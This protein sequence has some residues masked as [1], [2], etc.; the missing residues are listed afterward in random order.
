MS[1]SNL[2]ILA[3]SSNPEC[4]Q[5]IDKHLD[6]YYTIQYM[7]NGGVELSYD[8]KH[9]LMEGQ[10]FWPAYP[11]P[12]LAF[13]LAAGYESWNHRHVGF[14]GD[15]VLEWMEAGIWLAQPQAAPPGTDYEAFFEELV[16]RACI[17]DAWSRRLTINAIERLLI[18]LAQ[19]RS[20]ESTGPAAYPQWLQ[21]VLAQMASDANCDYDALAASEGMS[22]STLRRHFRREMGLSLHKYAIRRRIESARTLLLETELPLKAIADALGYENPYFFS[23]QFH[24]V[25]GVPPGMFR[26]S[27]QG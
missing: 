8:D 5:R 27:R 4:R 9:Y 18:E 26:K 6:G 3:A 10:W 11:G 1:K 24:E 13:H 7:S 14:S 17:R 2:I 20:A 19:A 21:R 22:A 15:L 23:R 25:V 12:R 16:Q